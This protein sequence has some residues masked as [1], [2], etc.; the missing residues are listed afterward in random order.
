VKTVLT[1][2]SDCYHH[3][4]VLY[5]KIGLKGDIEIFHLTEYLDRLICEGKIVPKNSIDETVT[6]HD[7]CHLGRL[8]ESWIHWDGE[9]KIEFDKRIHHIPQKEFRK[10]TNGVYEAP[11]NILKSIPGLRFVEMTR[12]KEYTWC[13]GAGGGVNDAY[14]EFN[15]WTANERL[16]EAQD[17]GANSIAT[18]CG[19][20]TRSLR[21]AA[22]KSGAQIK[23]FDVIELLERSI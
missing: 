17:T 22:E 19:W 13:C 14:P 15:L 1:N 8:G 21:D 23:V 7:P 2:C 12:I 18:A 6:Y 4:K 11:R 16:K 9:I 5:D 10:G 3:F 20:C